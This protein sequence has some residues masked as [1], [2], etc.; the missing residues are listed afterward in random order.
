MASQFKTFTAG[1]VLTASEVNTYL[2]KQAVIVCD[3]ST[4]YP[5]APV[6]GQFVFDKTLDTYLAYDGAAFVRVLPL[7][8]SAV[9]SWTPAITQTG[10]VTVTVNEAVYLRQG[11]FV[12]AWANLSVTGSGT[13]NSNVLTSLPVTSAMTSSHVVGSGFIFDS[14]DTNSYSVAVTLQ[15]G[16][17]TTAAFQTTDTTAAASWGVAPSVALASGDT[18]RFHIRYLVA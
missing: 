3:A 4:D 5:A 1:S 17:A 9:Q 7:D 18:I 2:M 15:G 12:D 8:A 11:A 14:S 6:E 10:S 16:A 13:G